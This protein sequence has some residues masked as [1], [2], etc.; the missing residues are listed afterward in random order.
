M[1]PPALAERR[2]K[3]V[4][5]ATCVRGGMD[6]ADLDTLVASPKSDVQ[7]GVGRILRQKADVRKRLPRWWWT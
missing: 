2:P 7:Q 5:L 6:G 3:S 4:M 1:K